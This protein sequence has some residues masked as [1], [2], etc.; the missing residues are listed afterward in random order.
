MGQTTQRTFTLTVKNVNRPPV[1]PTIADQVAYENSAYSLNV[2]SS[3]FS[4]TD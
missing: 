2:T 4:T 3:H 1:V